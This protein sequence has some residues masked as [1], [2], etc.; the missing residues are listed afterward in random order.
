MLRGVFDLQD[1]VSKIQFA[2]LKSNGSLDGDALE[3]SLKISAEIVDRTREMRYRQ[4]EGIERKTV[5]KLAGQANKL[6]K[7]IARL[8]EDLGFA[9]GLRGQN[10]CRYD[11]RCHYRARLPNSRASDRCGQ[12]IKGNRSHRQY[13]A[14]QH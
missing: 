10:R 1:D 2:Y 12:Q 4:I 8:K 11:P 3:E 7:A 13:A 6:D 9:E 14:W 5:S